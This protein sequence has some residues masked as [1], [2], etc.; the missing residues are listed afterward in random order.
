MNQQVDAWV[1][2]QKSRRPDP[3]GAEDIGTW[4]RIFEI[5]AATS[6]ISNMGIVFFTSESY[7]EGST[8]QMRIIYFLLCEHGIFMLRYLRPPERLPWFFV[9]MFLST[10]RRW[11]GLVVVAGVAFFL[12]V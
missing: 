8:W 9:L 4:Q 7:R 1:L 2:L 12:F 11:W 10:C 3:Y 5:L 6:I